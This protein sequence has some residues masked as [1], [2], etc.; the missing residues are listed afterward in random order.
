MVEK[1]KQIFSSQEQSYSLY[2]ITEQQHALRYLRD[3]ILN[4]DN[5]DLLE[6][7]LIRFFRIRPNKSYDDRSTVSTVYKLLFAA[8]IFPNTQLT[9]EEQLLSDFLN[10]LFHPPSPEKIN[11]AYQELSNVNP[12][13]LNDV[14]TYEIAVNVKS[15]MKSLAEHAPSFDWNKPQLLT[16][17]TRLHEAVYARDLDRITLL[18]NA[19]A[20]PHLVN[21]I[22]S[23]PFA[24]ALQSKNSAVILRF[25]TSSIFMSVL[26]KDEG[27]TI[28]NLLLDDMKSNDKKL[29][30]EFLS[31]DDFNP[32]DFINT[33]TD[34]QG[35]R[36]LAHAV[37]CGELKITQMLLNKGAC[38]NHDNE[39]R[40][41]AL[42]V[43]ANRYQ[44][45]YKPDH[46]A[47][48]QLLITAMKPQAVNVVVQDNRTAIEWAACQGH[49]DIVLMLLNYK[50]I[51]L[52]HDGNR[53]NILMAAIHHKWVDAI[54]RVLTMD[55]DKKLLNQRDNDW[56]TPLM[57]A[58]N[59]GHLDIT[60]MLLAAGADPSIKTKGGNTALSLVAS[61]SDVD[62]KPDHPAIVALLLKAMKATDVND[63]TQKN[64]TALE[65][66]VLKNNPDIVLL[67]VQYE[68][69]NLNEK[70]EGKTIY[71]IAEDKN[72]RSVK[73]AL[74][75]KSLQEPI[76]LE[77]QLALKD[78]VSALEEQ[79]RE[80]TAMI[81][82]QSAEINRLKEGATSA[83]SVG[84]A[85]RLSINTGEG[86]TAKPA[87]SPKRETQHNI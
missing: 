3:L 60:N 19:G 65:W 52:F 10:T 83:S 63:G 23:T 18:L 72:W 45:Q 13:D 48:A 57:L 50:D 62:P 71:Q 51:Q 38:A 70:I 27:N 1:L 44:S 41:T 39:K 49:H 76:T 79:V 25:I 74:K 80:L 6:R 58:A 84:T 30:L 55:V 35:Y 12:D 78:R 34:N 66:A 86:V 14:N 42:S 29:I 75:N 81:A 64:R 26:T 37:M 16:R 43:L 2:E 9:A 21:T 46:P 87:A 32:S 61:R 36:L 67:L 82:K 69:I 40:N 7:S 33:E 20:N 17:N 24:I 73:E 77:A 4:T 15:S 31:T 22:G 56:M 28:F 5:V 68:G 54:E 47:I 85:V 59:Y 8:K 11:G 53:Y